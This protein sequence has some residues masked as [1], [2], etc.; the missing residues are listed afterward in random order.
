MV[1]SSKVVLSLL[2]LCK[3]WASNLSVTAAAALFLTEKYSIVLSIL[4]YL[5]GFDVVLTNRWLCSNF[6]AHTDRAFSQHVQHM[7]TVQ[8]CQCQ[9][10]GTYHKTQNN[11]RSLTLT[12]NCPTTD[13]LLGV[14]GMLTSSGALHPCLFHYLCTE[15]K[16]SQ[17]RLRQHCLCIIFIIN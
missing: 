3:D 8:P 5:N 7:Y 10:C 12:Q 4:N 13:C 9:W 6:V 15:R 1:C 2:P 11:R 16:Q 14:S 17:I